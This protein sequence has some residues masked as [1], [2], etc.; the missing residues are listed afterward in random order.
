[1][2]TAVLWL[3]KIIPWNGFICFIITIVLSIIILL[4]APVEDSNKPLD[5]KEK[6]IFKK[7]IN[8][9]L[10]ILAGWTIFFWFIGMICFMLLLGKNKGGVL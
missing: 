3:I 4:I 10:C 5:Q 2:I 9:N 6:I 7:W 1:M 8:I